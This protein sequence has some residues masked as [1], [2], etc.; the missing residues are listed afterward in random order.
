MMVGVYPATGYSSAHTIQITTV[1]PAAGR[2]A[3]IGSWYELS[4][5]SGWTL[6]PETDIFHLELA[7]YDSTTALAAGTTPFEWHQTRTSGLWPDGPENEPGELGYGVS[8]G[9]LGDNNQHLYG[10]QN[11][12]PSQHNK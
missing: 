1:S 9:V 6:R 11:P 5:G 4:D 3:S 8:P 2:V 10:K 7:L 12:L